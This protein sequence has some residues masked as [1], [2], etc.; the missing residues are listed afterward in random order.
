MWVAAKAHPM[1]ERLRRLIDLAVH[2][3]PELADAPGVTLVAPD[4]PRSLSP[5]YWMPISSWGLFS[6]LMPA[7]ALLAPAPRRL[8]SLCLPGPGNERT[9]TVAA[10]MHLHHRATDIGRN[11]HQSAGSARSGDARGASRTRSPCWAA[12]ARLRA[13]NSISAD[14]CRGRERRHDHGLPARLSARQ[15]RPRQHRLS[16]RSGS[17]GS[18]HHPWP[19]ASG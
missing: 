2:Y 19:A 14:A 9:P 12:T 16:R 11:Q 3:R 8:A 5:R 13:V 7:K 18:A 17:A 4:S 15:P 6:G 10:G 1:G